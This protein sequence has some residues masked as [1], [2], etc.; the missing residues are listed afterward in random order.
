ML[1]CVAAVIEML[2][3][4][5]LGVAVFLYFGT[6]GGLLRVARAKERCRENIRSHYRN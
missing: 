1:G 6:I 2:P 5:S 4:E 3:E